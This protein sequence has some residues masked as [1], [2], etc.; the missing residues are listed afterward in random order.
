M[1]AR[2]TKLV[3]PAKSGVK[4]LA[5]CLPSPTGYYAPVSLSNFK[6]KA[7]EKKKSWY[8]IV[9]RSVMAR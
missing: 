7:M 4:E 6:E 1:I 3:P 2:T 5:E 8:A 9:M